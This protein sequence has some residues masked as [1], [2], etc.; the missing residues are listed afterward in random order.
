MSNPSLR[1][2]SLRR[3]LLAW[4]LP[5]VALLLLASGVGAYLSASRNATQAFDRTLFNLA[6]A[7]SNQVQWRGGELHFE[8]Q[9]Q[10]RQVLLT[11][12][13]DEIRYAVY[14]PA[15]ALLSGEEG[16]LPQSLVGHAWPEDGHLFFDG[17]SN[18]RPIRGVALRTTLV[19]QEIVVAVSE[20]LVKRELQVSEIVLN[21]LVPET[22]LFAATIGLVL[23]GVSAGL[24]P[25]EELRARLAERAPTDLQPI[26]TGREPLELKPLVEEIDRHLVRLGH[27]LEAQRHFVS[28]AAHQLRTPIAALIAQLESTRLESGDVR[29]DPILD[30]TRR[31]VRLVNQLLALARAEPGGMAAK[32][33]DLRALVEQEADGWLTAALAKEIDLGFEL[34]PAP[35]EGIALL[36]RELAGNLVDNAIRY[37]PAGGQVTV[38]VG[39][40]RRGTFLAVD[41]SGPGVPPELRERVFERFFRGDG[42]AAGGCGLGLA[43]VSQIAGQH[44]ASVTVGNSFEGGA[45]FLVR[46]PA[47][48]SRNVA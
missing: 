18:G 29:L 1:P 6:L 3:L 19:G 2:N 39:Q 46:F 36:L 16:V 15:G 47:G 34:A 43:I 20:T 28:D 31:L 8:L 26:A 9:P 17:R 27:A 23:F 40:D 38:R 35:V 44:R 5:G 41:D 7:F 42:G 37:T 25:L 12:K 48:D 14:G 32:P 45:S 13:F 30:S 21:T 22:L 33:V 4:L 11:D 24:R 10:T